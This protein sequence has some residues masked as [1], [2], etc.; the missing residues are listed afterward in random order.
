LP[1]EDSLG[2]PAAVSLTALVPD[3]FSELPHVSSEHNQQYWA[4]AGTSKQDRERKSHLCLQKTRWDRRRQCFRL[5]QFYPL[6]HHTSAVSTISNIGHNQEH[7]HGIVLG[8][9]TFA[10]RRLVGI[11]VVSVFGFVSSTHCSTT[12]LQ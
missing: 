8:K 3:F 9:I 12:R 1:A 7:R 6:Q 5:R 11:A 2:S 4:Q 10:C